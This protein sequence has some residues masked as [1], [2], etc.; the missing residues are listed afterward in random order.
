MALW[1]AIQVIQI[2][3]FDQLRQAYWLFSFTK[4]VQSFGGR[5]NVKARGNA[6]RGA[7]RFG[8]ETP[9]IHGVGLALFADDTCLYA[10][11]CKEGFVI[12]LQR[13]LSSMETWCERW[14]LKINEDKTRGTYYSRS[15]RPPESHL[16]LNGRD[17]ALVNSAK[18]LGVIFDRK[19]T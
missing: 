9:Q 16:S 14:N 17:I 8:L 11:D 2:G 19:V 3:V 1:L 7:N 12:K 6:S 4:K 15:H 18:Y 10:T 5:R 13:G